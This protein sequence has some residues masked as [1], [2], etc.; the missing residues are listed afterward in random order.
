MQTAYK[1]IFQ[2]ADF[3]MSRGLQN[4]NYYASIGGEV[5]IKWTAPEVWLC[6]H[7]HTLV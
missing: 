6:T 5:P 2:I 1:Y 3:G 4:E 7:I